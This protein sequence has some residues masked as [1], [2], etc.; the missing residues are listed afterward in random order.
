[1]Y[2][3]KYCGKEFDSGAKLGGHS[4]HC[5]ENP[6]NQKIYNCSFCNNEFTSL[7]GLHRH[8]KQC[9]ANPNAIK[10]Y[11]KPKVSDI[12]EDN[13][14]CQFC[15]KWCKNKNSLRNHERLCSKNPN[16]AVSS[17]D[18]YNTDIKT[19]VRTNW[20]KGKT[21]K[22]HPSIARTAKKLK[23][24]QYGARRPGWHHTEEA[25]RKIGLASAKNLQEGYAS[26]RISSPIGVGRGKYSYFMVNNKTYL[27][28]S[29]WEFIYALYLAVNNIEFE[30]EAI[31]VPAITKNKYSKTFISDFSY[32]NKVVEIKG[33]KSDKDYFLKES[34]EHAGYEFIELFECDINDIKSKLI[35]LGYDVNSL[36]DKIKVG[37][38]DK[39]YFTYIFNIK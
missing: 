14:F 25:K 27:L 26:G 29:T 30:V 21:A 36:I 28:R 17:L 15:G 4:I 38:K 37:H 2:K 33:I 35:E 9:K 18:V 10:E 8:E 6:N 32:D 5:K 3:C 23:N 12:S 16:K 34:F 11:H 1:M 22:T 20:A 13:L 7:N 31:R 24:N 19:G 39:N